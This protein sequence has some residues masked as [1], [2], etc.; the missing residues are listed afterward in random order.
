MMRDRNIPDIEQD[1]VSLWIDILVKQLEMLCFAVVGL[2]ALFGV[3][4]IYYNFNIAFNIVK[5]TF[6][7][8]IV[9]K[10]IKY[11]HNNWKKYVQSIKMHP[12]FAPFGM[13]S[14]DYDSVSDDKND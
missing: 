12:I 1:D 4:F 13:P 6:Y 9:I 3:L 2:L 11:I 14:V 10:F 8:W 5:W 7:S